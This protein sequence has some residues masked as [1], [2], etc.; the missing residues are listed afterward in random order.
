M[1]RGSEYPAKAGTAF[2]LV[3]A[4]RFLKLAVTVVTDVNDPHL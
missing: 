2:A 3:L 1:L 4:A